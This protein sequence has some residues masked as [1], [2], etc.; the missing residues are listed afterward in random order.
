MHSLISPDF[1]D[2]VR[3]SFLKRSGGLHTKQTMADRSPVYTITLKFDFI[4]A[5]GFWPAMLVYQSGTPTWRA[6]VLTKQVFD[7][8]VSL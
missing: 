8:L 2:V 5:L 4:W 1:P 6:H 7:I 3:G